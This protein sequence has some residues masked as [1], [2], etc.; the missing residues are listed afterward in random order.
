MANSSD[1]ALIA[2]ARGQRPVRTPVWFL[3]Q[4]GRYLPEYMK[5]RANIEFVDLCKSPKL[6]AEV[7]MQPLRRYDLDAAIIFSDILIPCTAM[8]QDLTFDKGHGPV[9]SQPIRTGADLK[10][11]RHPDC[12]R[13]LGY[14]GDGIR[15]TTAQLSPHHT[16]IG[17][18]G[19]PFTVASYMIEGRGSKT[20]TEVKRLRYND[21]TTL[22]GLLDLLADV[23]TDYL[24]MQ[25]K[26]GAECLMLFDTWAG[27]MTAADYREFVFPATAKV[28]AAVRANTSVPLIYYPGQG[29]DLYYELSGLPAYVIAVDWRM[30]LSRAISVLRSEGLNVSVQGNLD[31]QA[32]IASESE[33]RARTRA[34]LTDG[35]AARGHIFNVGHG[36]LP[37]T[38]PEAPAWVV[39]EIRVFDEI[40]RTDRNG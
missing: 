40:R 12:E 34:I 23:T 37:H 28:M 4:A 36:L 13:E 11:L 26:A 29:L 35:R 31:P 17:F 30:R 1:K 33:L 16:M 32:M 25:V 3:R 22:S 7:T 27:Q 24:L 39:D 14:V 21:T 8:G 6:V 2:A 10:R 18:A 9:L 5:I 38:P 15:A 20:Y 19:A